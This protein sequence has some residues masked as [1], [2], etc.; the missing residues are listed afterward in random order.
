MEQLNHFR[1]DQCD[2]GV[3]RVDD[4]FRHLLARDLIIIVPLLIV[5]LWLWGPQSQLASQRRGGENHYRAAVR[6]AR[7]RHHRRAAAA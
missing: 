4:R 7:R 5:G 6:H 1:P 3:S 2:P